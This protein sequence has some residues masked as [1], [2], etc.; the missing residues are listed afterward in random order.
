M[1]GVAGE[2]TA[3]SAVEVTVATAVWVMAQ[4][5]VAVLTLTRGTGQSLQ[6][7]WTGYWTASGG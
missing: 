6:I 3:R 4:A 1:G 5:G 2:A 7:Y